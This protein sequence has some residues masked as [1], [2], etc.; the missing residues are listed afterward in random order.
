[1]YVVKLSNNSETRASFCWIGLWLQYQI[2]SRKKPLRLLLAKL[3]Q[4]QT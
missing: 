1:M 3:K 2:E 4:I